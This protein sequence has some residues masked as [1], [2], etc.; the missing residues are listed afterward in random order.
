MAT[1]SVD[2][3]MLDDKGKPDIEKIRPIVY[4]PEVRRYHGIGAF[5][6]K[7]FDIGKK[8]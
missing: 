8:G 4:S 3:S 6:G 2:E 7:A 5:I 1:S